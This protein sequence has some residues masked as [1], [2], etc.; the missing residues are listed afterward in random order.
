MSTGNLPVGTTYAALA[1]VLRGMADLV[2]SGDSFEG[3]IEY[4]IP[5]SEDTLPPPVSDDE[6]PEVMVRAIFRIGNR[7]GQGGMRIY[8]T[9]GGTPHE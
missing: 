5:T 7:D 4:L 9:L 1:S 3:S 8:G 2:E 6:Q